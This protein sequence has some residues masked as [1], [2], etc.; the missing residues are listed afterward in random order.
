VSSSGGA[1]PKSRGAS[2]RSLQW[3][4]VGVVVLL[5]VLIIL[6]PDLFSSDTSGLQTRAQLI[7]ERVAQENNTSYYV[8]SIG[9]STVYA[10]ISVGLA[11]LPSWPY[12]GTTSG[13]SNW[14]WTNGTETLV[15]VAT[16]AMNPVAVNVTVKYLAASGLTT[17]YVGAYGFDINA[18]TMTLLA[19]NLLPGGTAPAASTPLSELPIYLL[20][21]IQTTSRSSS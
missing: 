8:E 9:T 1:P 2:S 21:A 5:L 11:R 7:V 15:L 16:N 10:S 20:L 17:E 6:T 18:T 19:V 12:T 3:P 13:L 14:T 4:F